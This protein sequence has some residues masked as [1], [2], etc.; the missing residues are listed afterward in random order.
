MKEETI[1]T[2]NRISP[3]V[4]ARLPRYY[5]YLGD[6]IEE[7]V[8]HISSQELSRIMNITASQIRQDLNYFGE[9]GKQ[10][11]GYC[12]RPLQE[13]IG[14]L[15]GLDREHSMILIGS[16]NL[17][18]ALINYMNY[19]SRGFLFRAAFDINPALHGKCFSGVQVHPMEELTDFLHHHD[20]E[21]AVI[22]I[23]RQEAVKVVK[24]I[25]DTGRIKAI[26]NFSHTDLDVP[27]SVKVENV[28]LSESL[29]KLSF[30]ISSDEV[31]NQ[32]RMKQQRKQAKH[33]AE[34]GVQEHRQ[35]RSPESRS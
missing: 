20:I 19:R 24:T 14:K 7:G 28:H 4:I 32:I 17:G 11:Q 8:E 33:A 34:E 15:L 23:P 6:L 21:I 31:K 25:C 2:Y 10:G 1:P 9:F 30:S 18:S 22:A 5:R 3:A 12:T 26:W 29:M 35:P 13:E 16:G 27:E